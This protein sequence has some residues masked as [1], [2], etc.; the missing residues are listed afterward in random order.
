MKR[1]AEILLQDALT[2]SEEERA[3]IAGALLKSL[4]PESE[5]DIEAAWREEVAAR[6][7]ARDAGEME[8]VPWS[9]IRDGLLAG[10][11]QNEWPAS[12]AALAGAWPDFPTLEEI[13]QPIGEDVSRER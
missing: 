8:T 4:E 11:R 7:A 1:R 5:A 3:E 12:V 10:A 9:E 2:L 13:R 6:V